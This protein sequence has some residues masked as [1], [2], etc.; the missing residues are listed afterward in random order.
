VRKLTLTEEQFQALKFGITDVAEVY[1]TY[2]NPGDNPDESELKHEA[3][4]H[5]CGELLE[6]LL[7]TQL[8]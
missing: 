1:A 4:V 6:E 7:R 5:K 3:E 8:K 2:R